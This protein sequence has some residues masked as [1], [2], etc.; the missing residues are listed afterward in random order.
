MI[1]LACGCRQVVISPETDQLHAGSV[2][3][4]T[5]RGRHGS[6]SGPCT[7]VPPVPELPA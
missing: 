5:S 3:E 4:G 2:I 6:G 7:P 1:V